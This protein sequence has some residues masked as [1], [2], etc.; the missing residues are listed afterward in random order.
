MNLFDYFNEICQIP[1]ESGNEEGM[2]KYLLSWASKNRIEATKDKAGNIIARIPAS[3]GY[4][5]KPSVALQGHM[6]MVCVK[7]PG[8]NHDF[9]KDPIETYIDKD[10]LRAKDTS[11]GGDNGI[12]IAM[13]MAAF[14]DPNCKHGPLEAIFTFSEE[15]GMDGAFNLD[16]S[17]IQSRRLINLDSE[18]EGVIY[19]GCAGGI[20]IVANQEYKLNDAPK[21]AKALKINIEGLKGGHSGGEIH[22]QRLNAISAMARLLLALEKE[23][24]PF[25]IKSFDGGVRRNVIP[26]TCKCTI[27]ISNSGYEKAQKAIEIASKNLKEENKFEEPNLKIEYKLEDCLNCEKNSS[28]LCK[29]LSREN[30]LTIAKALFALPHGVFA[31]SKAL[32][33][34]VET[35]DNLAIAHIKDGVFHLEMSVRSNIDSA[36]Y[37]LANKIY[38]ILEAFGIKGHIGEGYPSWSPNPNSKLAKF[39]AKAYEDNTGKKAVVTAIHAGLECGVINS[40]VP[41]MDSVSIGPDLFDVHS[42][43][44][45]LSISSAQRTYD[46]VKHLLSIIE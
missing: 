22:L 11:L 23:G 27:F 6:D 46:F 17:L 21:E 40:I 34:I 15:T 28:G 13:T 18:E 41:G 31:M 19:I 30:S 35:S 29:A 24:C 5:N 9:T 44:E 26:S 42:T 10:F 39:C 3:K 1:R 16:G 7:V 12:G 32:P 14:T 37:F 45:H 36:K 20:D 8:S 33:G 38:T 25:M 43:N 2:R 4:E